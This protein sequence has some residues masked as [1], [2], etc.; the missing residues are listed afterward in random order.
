MRL[1]LLCNAGFSLEVPDGILLI[2]LPNDVQPPFY[3]LPETVWQQ[4]LNKQPPYD[5]VVGFCFTHVHPDHYSSAR[6]E[7]YLK[8]W[9][10]TLCFVPGSAQIKGKGNIGPFSIRFQRIEHAP[11]PKAPPHVVLMAEADGRAIYFS[12]D[13]A[14]ECEKHRKFLEERSPDVAV[15]NSM[16]LSRTDTR[17]MLNQVSKTNLICHM[18]EQSADGA[19][20]YWRKLKRNLER[21]NHELNSVVIPTQYPFEME[22]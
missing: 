1:T 21:F 8:R 12:G 14:L 2:D 17:A 11:I 16:Y 6:M 22:M 15:W 9:P 10:D 5:R 18:P 4:I 3:Q 20:L 7:T 13:A 19:E